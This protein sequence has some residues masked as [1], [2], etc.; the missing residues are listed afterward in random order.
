[1]LE[2]AEIMDRSDGPLDADGPGPTPSK[3]ER[4]SLWALMALGFL[5]ILLI[6]IILGV[7]RYLQVLGYGAP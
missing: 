4:S 1:M 2:D 7:W 5:A 6:W 3:E